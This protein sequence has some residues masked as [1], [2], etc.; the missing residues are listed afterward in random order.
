MSEKSEKSVIIPAIFDDCEAIQI[1]NGVPA[2]VINDKD[3]TNEFFNVPAD[4]FIRRTGISER[5]LKDLSVLL[6]MPLYWMQVG[7]IEDDYRFLENPS[8]FSSYQAYNNM[9]IA[10][11]TR[12]S[13]SG[14]SFGARLFTIILQYIAP[15]EYSETGFVSLG[16]FDD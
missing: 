4:E 9:L 12:F 7:H 3:G 10:R 15:D 13:T 5:V 1:V 2:L 8:L 14:S 11:G 16:T 6:G